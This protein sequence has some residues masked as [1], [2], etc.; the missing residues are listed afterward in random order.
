MIYH[1]DHTNNVYEL[2]LCVI[3]QSTVAWLTHINHNLYTLSQY[4][5]TPMLSGLD[6]Y[7]NQVIIGNFIVN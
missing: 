1:F 4:D 5:M 3:C 2:Y 7:I 6:R